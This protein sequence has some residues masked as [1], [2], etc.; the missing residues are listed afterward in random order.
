MAQT[1]PIKVFLTKYAM[2]WGKILISQIR[3]IEKPLV[4]N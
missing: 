4:T 3:N 2:T 1:G